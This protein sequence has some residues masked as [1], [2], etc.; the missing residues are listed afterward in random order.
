MENDGRT[1]PIWPARLAGSQARRTT[2]IVSRFPKPAGTTRF[3]SL[4][5]Q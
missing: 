4:N 2:D 1:Q 3:E 5:A